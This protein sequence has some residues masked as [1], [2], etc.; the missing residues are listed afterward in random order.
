MRA[1]LMLLCLRRSSTFAPRGTRS[2][3]TRRAAKEPA[4]DAVVAAGAAERRKRLDRELAAL[5][6]DAERLEGDAA[7]RGS[8]ALAT[9]RRF[10]IPKSGAS[11]RSLRLHSSLLWHRVQQRRQPLP[12]PWRR[13]RQAARRRA[14]GARLRGAEEEPN[15]PVAAARAELGPDPDTGLRHERVVLFVRFVVR[16]DD[17]VGRRRAHRPGRPASAR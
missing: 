16:A 13:R 7:L 3:V 4:D 11:R 15:R 6:F 12:R 10:V 17:V 2:L 1:A 9:Y 5:G 14:R 8:A